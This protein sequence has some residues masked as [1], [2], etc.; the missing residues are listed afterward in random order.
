[1]IPISQLPMGRSAILVRM[2]GS[3]S[4]AERLQRYGLLAGAPISRYAVMPHNRGGVWR[5]G[6]L[7]IALR[8][9]EAAHLLCRMEEES[10]E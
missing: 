7:L 1:M 2:E 4:V 5:Q 6:S 10:H 9:Q 8:E 3:R